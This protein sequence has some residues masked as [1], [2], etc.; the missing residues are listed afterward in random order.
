MKIGIISDTHGMYESW[1]S[2]Y[3]KFLHDCDCLLHAGDILYHGPRNPVLKEYNPAKLAED[4]NSL[5][6]TILFAHGNCDAEVDNMIIQHPIQ[7]PYTTAYLNGKLTIISHGH[8]FD[9]AEE[10]KAV[11]KRFKAGVFVY[12]HIHL[13]VLE[14]IDGITYLNPGSPALSKLENRRGTFALWDNNSVSIRYCD[15]GEIIKQV[16]FDE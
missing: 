1:R 14:T 3:V 2:V 15:N 5:P 11:A 7:S 4:L 6:Q 16:D 10:I 9:A 12:G 8:Y 13:P